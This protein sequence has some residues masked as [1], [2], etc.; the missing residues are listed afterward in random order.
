MPAIAVLLV[1]S[2]V[3]SVITL[4]LTLY[5]MFQTPPPPPIPSPKG[6][7]GIPEA[8]QGM[9]IPVLFGK[10]WISKANVVW[11]GN[12]HSTKIQVDPSEL[13]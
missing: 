10:R 7:T 3:L 12:P 9:D 13:Q 5:Q 6:V 8:T 2:Q 11:W 4:G 1:I